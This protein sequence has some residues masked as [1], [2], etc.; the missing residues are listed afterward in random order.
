MKKFIYL[1][2][3][4]FITLFLISC[5]SSVSDLG[6]A[7]N[8]SPG[9]TVLPEI[10]AEGSLYNRGFYNTE[11]APE[12][13]FPLNTYNTSYVNLKN[14][15][16]NDEIEA[17]FEKI[18][19]EE[20][21][22]YFSYDYSYDKEKDFNIAAEVAPAPWDSDIQTLTIGINAKQVNYDFKKPSNIVFLIDTSISMVEKNKLSLV[23]SSLNLFIDS[24]D[25]NDLVSIITYGSKNKIDFSSMDAY[26]IQSAIEGLLP[27]RPILS[28]KSIHAAYARAKENFIKDGINE[29]IIITDGDFNLGIPSMAD[30]NSYIAKQ[31][32]EEKIY[33]S[34]FGVGY[35][36]EVDEVL[37]S[38]AISG[39]GI[40]KYINT[41][42]EFRNALMEVLGY[43]LKVIS[44]DVNL[45]I[46]FNPMVV[47]EYRLIGYS[48][49][50]KDKDQEDIDE[51]GESGVNPTKNIIYEGHSVTAIYEIKYTDH[52]KSYMSQ[53]AVVA[54][55]EIDYISPSTKEV[56]TEEFKIDFKSKLTK[57]KADIEFILDVVEFALV[58]NDS[59][60]SKNAKIG[61]ILKRYEGKRS[62]I[63][64][65]SKQ[66]FYNL[67]E[68]YKSKYLDLSN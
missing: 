14:I 5:S 21:I 57:N 68:K 55:V 16:N 43:K 37:E 66:D 6:N 56:I 34:V 3:L 20:L 63:K 40:Y 25:N 27:G 26:L 46:K 42:S 39:N 38:L 1:V 19:V 53:S 60:Q 59:S 17:D 22:N 31:R 8:T 65:Q 36:N 30:L 4:V 51:D 18:K 67:V 2:F 49:N 28:A 47:E 61:N 44:D 32:D 10:D 9:D 45:I 54:T 35:N 48:N 11:A 24:L 29:I 23:Q 15:I 13:T 64:D 50:S 52:Y 7:D 58:L 33:L 41:V 62:E 12:S